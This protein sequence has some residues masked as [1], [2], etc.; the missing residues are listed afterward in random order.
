MVTMAS[1]KSPICGVGVVFHDLDIL[2]YVCAPEKRR[3]LAA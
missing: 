3:R 1:Q 2:M